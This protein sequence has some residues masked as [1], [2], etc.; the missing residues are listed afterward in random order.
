[1]VMVVACG[2]VE[3]DHERC[4]N[5]IV[6][7]HEACDDGN[8]VEGD[9]CRSDCTLPRCGDGLVDSGEE[10]D[11]G[12]L[13]DNDECT[14]WCAL[15]LCPNGALDPG[16]A[17]DDGDYN[18]D[19]DCLNDCTL[20]PG[21]RCGDGVVDGTEQCDD[22]NNS[23]HDGCTV[24][25]RW[26]YCGDGYLN[27]GEDCDDGGLPDGCPDDC[28]FPP[29]PECG[30]GGPFVGAVTN[31][32]QPTAPGDGV[33]IPWV[34]DGNLG[35]QAGESMCD[36]VGATRVCT[37]AEVE[38]AWAYGQLDNLPDGMTFWLHRVDETVLIDKGSELVWSE[39]GAG[40]RCN[41]WATA[42]SWP[43]ANGEYGY[44]QDGM[45]NYVFDQDTAFTGMPDEHVGDGPYDGGPCKGTARAV[46]CCCP[47]L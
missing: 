26:T 4:G 2:A 7:G 16:E 41:D 31:A 19:N 36:A 13:I 5:G 34:H 10:C 25:C 17:C 33:S 24:D 27:P 30:A 40:G 37:Y 22:A 8:G 44:M 3:V 43:L 11:D 32:Q 1:M 18:D 12:N 29:E 38:D 45:V 28:A 9:G 23:N 35:L 39:P 46:L 14:N 21:P 6:D 47:P 20:P 15:R 42:T